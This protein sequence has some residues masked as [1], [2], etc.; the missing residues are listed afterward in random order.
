MRS[1][2]QLQGEHPVDSGD[3]GGMQTVMT[4]DK[5][6]ITCLPFCDLRLEKG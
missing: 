3:M 4:I 6:F 2:I 5:H 1:Y